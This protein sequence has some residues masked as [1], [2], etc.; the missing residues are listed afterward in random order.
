MDDEEDRA[1]G[2]L[3]DIIFNSTGD[4]DFADFGS[5]CDGGDAGYMSD[6]ATDQ[7]REREQEQEQ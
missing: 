2:E 6:Q 4:D 7:E 1:D 3:A 5:E